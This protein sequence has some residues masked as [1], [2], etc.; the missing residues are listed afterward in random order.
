MTV[1][2]KANSS[3]IQLQTAFLIKQKENTNHLKLANMAKF[4]T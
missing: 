1:K 4:C 2:P 3:V